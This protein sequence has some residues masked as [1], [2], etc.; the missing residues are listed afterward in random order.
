[1][2]HVSITVAGSI[3]RFRTVSPLHQLI[4]HQP[5]TLLNLIDELRIREDPQVV[6]RIPRIVMRA[7]STASMPE[8]RISLILDSP[9]CPE[10]LV[11]MNFSGRASAVSSEFV[12]TAPGMMQ[13]TPMPYFSKSTRNASVSPRI[14]NFNV[15]YS[16]VV[17]NAK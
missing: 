2:A 6:R 7:R 14:A 8:A 11:F 17:G 16:A 15:E 9:S 1:L 4:H 5:M 10:N 12:R 3:R 13:E